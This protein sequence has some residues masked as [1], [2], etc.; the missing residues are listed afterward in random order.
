MLKITHLNFWLNQ[1]QEK[2]VFKASLLDGSNQKE[3][4]KP[5][6]CVVD[7][8]AGDSL[9]RIAKGLYPYA[10]FWPGQLDEIN[11]VAITV[12]LNFKKC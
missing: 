1:T 6:L 12:S 3:S 11:V 8:W 10:V 2:L 7:R 4:V 5:Q 9:T